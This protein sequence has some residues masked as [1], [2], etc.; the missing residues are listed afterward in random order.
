MR[1]PSART[2]RRCPTSRRR[3][4]RSRGRSPTTAW[5]ARFYG[6]IVDTAPHP[7][8]AQVLTN[9]MVTRPG[10]ESLV[11]NES[12]AV[13]PDV[14]NTG[15]RDRQRAG[16]PRVHARGDHGVPGVLARACSSRDAIASPTRRPWWPLASLPVVRTAAAGSR[17][18]TAAVAAGAAAAVHRRARL[19]GR[20][21][22]VP[23]PGGGARG[24]RPRLPHGVRGVD[25]RRDAAAHDPA[26]AR[27]ARRSAWCSGTG[28]A[29]AATRVPHRL[30]DPA[31]RSRSCRSSCRPSPT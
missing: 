24:R 18:L 22:A 23:D 31:R 19:P 27:L 17:W 6:G 28:L 4:R 14:P 25:V 7:N 12:V 13:L 15:R 21:A 10:Q 9:F 16:G 30:A 20:G 26:G 11:F 8:A 2:T 1:S 5:G 29:W 3:A